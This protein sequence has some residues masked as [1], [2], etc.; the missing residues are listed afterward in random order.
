MPFMGGREL[1]AA[2]RKEGM[3]MP[4][5]A[6]TAA[7]NAAADARRGGFAALLMKPLSLER[8]REALDIVFASSQPALRVPLSSVRPSTPRF[9]S[10]SLLVAPHAGAA[11]SRSAM[12]HAVFAASWP[13]DDERL[14]AAARRGDTESFLQALHRVNGAL[15]ALGEHEASRCCSA[16]RARVC[17]K[18]IAAS[19]QALEVFRRGVARI[20][21]LGAAM[22]ADDGEATQE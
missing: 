5:I 13:E 12:L 11:K 1:L 6:H 20:A 2:L 18:G 4:V 15:L 22:M 21:E 10:T 9:P 14:C 16:L 7:P 19:A 17:A 8:L 3:T